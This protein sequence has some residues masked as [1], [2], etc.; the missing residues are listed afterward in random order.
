MSE[1]RFL[2]SLIVSFI[3]HFS[4]VA[5]LVLLV[6]L[7]LHC[8]LCLDS[9]ALL[10]GLVTRHRVLFSALGVVSLCAMIPCLVQVFLEIAA[11]LVQCSMPC[12]GFL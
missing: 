6:S 1:L 2:L 10:H 12:F 11:K 9:V 8:L 5:S 3:S 4:C 7:V